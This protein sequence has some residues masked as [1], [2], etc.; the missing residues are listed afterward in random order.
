MNKTTQKVNNGA[1]YHALICFERSLSTDKER[2]FDHKIRQ[3]CGNNVSIQHEHW[4][5]NDIYNF[6]ACVQKVE[7]K[8]DSLRDNAAMQVHR[9][10]DDDAGRVVA[11]SW[12]NKNYSRITVTEKPDI[13]PRK[14][15]AIPLSI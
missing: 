10:H 9:A 7:E 6:N 3:L 14:N 11:L 2:I 8:F 12:C 15:V 4:L 5:Q 1:R 13:S